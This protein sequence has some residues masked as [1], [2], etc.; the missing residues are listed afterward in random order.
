MAKW[1]GELGGIH[2]S[3][4][5]PWVQLWRARFENVHLPENIW[6][7]LN[8]RDLREKKKKNEDGFQEKK[9]NWFLQ[10]F[11]FYS[12]V[13]FPPPSL[14]ETLKLE[15]SVAAALLFFQSCR[16]V[17]P[18]ESC[19]KDTKEKKNII[20]DNSN[21]ENLLYVGG[22]GLYSVISVVVF[23]EFLSF[24]QMPF[25]FS[26]SLLFL[27]FFFFFHLPLKFLQKSD[28][29]CISTKDKMFPFACLS[30]YFESDACHWYS[31]ICTYLYVKQTF[32]N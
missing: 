21:N 9:N 12:C 27:G 28:R 18:V 3:G 4:T 19:M 16:L 23:F 26:F 6:T 20:N 2:G 5:N 14:F 25:C 15:S 32:C 1:V 11:F 24:L 8:T 29:C 10:Y 30:V 22:G 13:F 7:S 17:H 31:S